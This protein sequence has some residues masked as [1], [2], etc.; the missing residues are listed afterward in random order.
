MKVKV[1]TT[2]YYPYFPL[3]SQRLAT[4]KLDTTAATSMSAVQA[5]YNSCASAIV[6]M[7][8]TG[9][10]AKEAAKYR[11]KCPVMAVTR[12]AQ[13]ARQLQLHRGVIPLFYDGKCRC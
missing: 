13:V 12:N 6:V 11:P 10:T 7:T 5:A 8:S 9:R 2:Y 3:Q 1:C 4:V